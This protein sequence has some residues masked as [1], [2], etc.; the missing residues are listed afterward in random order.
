MKPFIIPILEDGKLILKFQCEGRNSEQIKETFEGTW[1][2]AYAMPDGHSL[3]EV[4]L[5]RLFFGNDYFIEFSSACSGVGGWREIGSLNLRI[6]RIQNSDQGQESGIFK[7][8]DIE[9]FYV[10]SI[11]RLV[12]EDELVNVE[13]GIVFKDSNGKLLTIAAGIPPGSVSVVGPFSNGDFQPEF[14]I[15]DYK[16]VVI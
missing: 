5:F 11:T 3:K 2:T 14:A 6:D 1:I 10:S 4:W 16:E 12:Y 9:P 13:G 15:A 8:K 7:K